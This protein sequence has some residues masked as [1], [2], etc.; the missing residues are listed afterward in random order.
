MEIH[1]SRHSSG[2]GT[3][4]SG[5]ESKQRTNNV[6]QEIITM[7]ESKAKAISN[8]KDLIIW[9]AGKELVVDIYRLT[10]TFPQEEWF[11][12]TDQ[13]RRAAVSVPSNIAEGFN[14]KYSTDYKRFLFVALGSCGELD[15]QLEIAAALQMTNPANVQKLADKIDHES[16]MIRKLIEKIEASIKERKN[17]KP[18]MSSEERIQNPL[19]Y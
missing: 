17:L 5:L 15:T 4:S 2:L 8:F 19:Q 6:K 11:G 3:R 18:K 1:I 9:K 14:R 12:L 7:E 13:M 10:K 16:R